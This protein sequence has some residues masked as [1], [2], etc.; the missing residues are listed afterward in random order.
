[1]D[2]YIPNGLLCVL[3]DWF[4]NSVTCVRWGNIYSNYFYLDCGVRQGGIL[5][6]QLFAVYIDHVVSALQQSRLG[7]YIKL[8]C[9]S[10]LVYADDIIILAPSVGSLQKLLCI[11]ENALAEIDMSLNSKKSVCIRVGARHDAKCAC[12]TTSDG[13]LLNW[14][15]SCRYL[16]IYFIASRQFKCSLDNSKK[17]FYRSFNSIFGKVGR[18]ASEEVVL[19]LINVKCFPILLYG[20]DACPITVSDMRSLDF[21]LN[22]IL[23]KL[24]NTSRIDIINECRVAFNL[25]LMSELVT[26]RKVKFLSKFLLNENSICCLFNA[27]AKVELDE[28]SSK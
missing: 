15:I 2:R 26:A 21:V 17:A 24:F 9:V 22:R 18:S 23:M 16:G 5:S 25:K 1:M 11:C 7:C 28:L 6:P 10:V 8:K 20:L 19:Q 13:D 14:V 12:I 4:N 3:E 27:T